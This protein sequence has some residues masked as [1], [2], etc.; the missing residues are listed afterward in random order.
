MMN[1]ERVT[2]S[3]EIN[4]IPVEIH[5]DELPDWVMMICRAANEPNAEVSVTII[6]DEEMQQMNQ[7]Y[8]GM[9]KPTDV[10]SFAM[11][12]GATAD[13]V[14]MLGDIVISYD[15]AKR[16]AIDL[17]HSVQ[18]E[19]KELIFH[20]MMHLL[21]CDHET[22]AKEWQSKEDDLIQSLKKM[23]SAYIPLGIHADS[24][25]KIKN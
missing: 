9:D 14:N 4:P 19:M 13:S 20:G 1:L 11:R 16:Q 6:A 8:R 22:N 21:G 5:L 10:L 17:G 25:I 2:V 23:N 24:S 3:I 7:Q 15:T 12:E 18:T